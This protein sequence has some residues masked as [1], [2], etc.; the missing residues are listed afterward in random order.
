[1]SRMDLGS[2]LPIN[3]LKELSVGLRNGGEMSFCKLGTKFLI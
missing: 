1:V 2:K 3:N